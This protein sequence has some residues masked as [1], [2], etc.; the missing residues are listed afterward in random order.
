MVFQGKSYFVVKEG[1]ESSKIG[2]RFKVIK[3]LDEGSF[4]QVFKVNDLRDTE[5]KLAIKICSE[6]A[7]F[8]EEIKAMVQI[9]RKTLKA[10]PQ[11]QKYYSTPEVIQSGKL[12]ALPKSVIKAEAVSYADLAAA[13]K[14]SFVVM[15]RYGL[16]IEQYYEATKTTFSKANTYFIGYAVLQLLEQVHRA[17]YVFNDLKPDNLITCLDESIEIKNS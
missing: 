3:K 8:E 12:V 15:P 11:V 14:Y 17:G 2:D 7:S 4:G 6:S 1:F 9:H 5:R 13:N 10:Y 16:N